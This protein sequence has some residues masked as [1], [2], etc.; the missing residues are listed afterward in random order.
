[1]N[2][3]EW[4][5]PVYTILMQLGTGIL[6]AL[7]L[8]R[9]MN[10]KMVRQENID[11]LF[12]R[13]VLVIF[14]T[15]LLA[16]IGSHFH[17]SNPLLSFLAIQNIRHSWLSREI[18]FTILT[19]LTV[20]ALVDQTWKQDNDNVRL[21]TILG[22]LAVLLGSASIYCMSH[23]YLLP[24]QTSWN[25]LTTILMFFSS[26]LVLGTTSAITLVFMDTIFINKEESELV[27]VR[28]QILKRSLRMLIYL[29]IAGEILI[30]ILNTTQILRM[31]DGDEQLQTSLSLLLGLYQ[32]LLIIRFVFLFSGIGF[33][34]LTAFWLIKKGKSLTELVL[35]IYMA[36]L[37]VLVAEILGRFL[38]YATHVRMGI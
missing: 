28:L 25:H 24:T 35:P 36:C 29:V 27:N 14:I 26:S 2:V 20:A 19:F 11:K 4:A 3:R 5:L 6:F 18:V 13:P 17:L 10:M 21:S 37:L 12:R 23:I 15:I 7:W 31:H 16:I 9:S 1:M 32:P 30:V 34:L 22:W 33:V 8:V 38:F